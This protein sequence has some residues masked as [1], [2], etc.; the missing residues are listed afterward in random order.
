VSEPKKLTA[1]ERLSACHPVQV[2][3]GIEGVWWQDAIRIAEEHA[4]AAVAEV[5]KERDAAL[6][7]IA[8]LDRKLSET[9]ASRSALDCQYAGAHGESDGASHCP[10]DKPCQRCTLE[11]ERDEAR[12][13]VERL[14]EAAT[15]LL[16]VA[17][18]SED[19]LLPP[20][21]CD[22]LLWAART[23][24]AWDDLRAALKA[25]DGGEGER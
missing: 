24:D 3:P 20:P 14:R 17:D 6:Q 5:T 4:D 23:Q 7:R 19:S 9:Y 25:A 8:G 15:E 10:P 18:L 11:R 12:A 22:P 16:E 13:E 1:E 21:E 2:A